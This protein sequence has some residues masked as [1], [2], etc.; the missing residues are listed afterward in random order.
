MSRLK[1]LSAISVGVFI[2]FQ[3]RGALCKALWWKSDRCRTR[4]S[5]RRVTGRQAGADRRLYLA[6]NHLTNSHSA[7]STNTSD[8]LYVFQEGDE[9]ASALSEKKTK[10]EKTKKRIAL[11]P[12]ERLV[13]VANW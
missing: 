7:H 11:V 8:P 5:A 13:A 1:V 12:Q 3:S 2:Y 4:R 6:V 10:N 9:F